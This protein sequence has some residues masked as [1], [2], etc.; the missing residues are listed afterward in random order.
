MFGYVRICKPELRM[1]DWDRYQGVYCTLCRQLGRRYGCLT[2]L[3]LSYDVTFLAVLRLALADDCAGFEPGRCVYRPTKKC[4]RCRNTDEVD[5][6]ATCAILLLGVKLRDTVQDG[7]FWKRLTARMA[8]WYLR[9]ALRKAEAALPEEAAAVK[10]YEASQRQVESAEDFSLDR[11]AQPTAALIEEWLVRVGSTDE[12]RRAL[13]RLGYCIGRF[14]YLAD[15]ADDYWEDTRKGGYNP[16][17]LAHD[18]PDPATKPGR[19]TR[20]VV[21]APETVR[22]HVRATLNT[23]WAEALTAYRLLTLKRFDGILDNIMEHGMAAVIR[24]LMDGKE[25]VG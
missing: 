8:L 4:L 24:Q 11:A 18:P 25:A 7:G 16:W 20:G 1:G 21:G 10:A 17:L 14:V 3:T 19:K 13:G 9:R 12:Q 6:A 23:C 2:R 22:E 15:A 5:Y